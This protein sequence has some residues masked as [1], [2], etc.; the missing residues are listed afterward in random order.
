MIK[1]TTLVCPGAGAGA[2]TLV[3]RLQLRLRLRPKVSA[4]AGSR[5]GSGSATL[6][7][8]HVLMGLGSPWVGTINH[9]D[10]TDGSCVHSFC[11]FG[12]R[13]QDERL[14]NYSIDTPTL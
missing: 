5:S 1:Y 12:H 6:I 14:I 9:D 2:E 11:S 10:G 13:T 4:P 7:L 3:H 8:V